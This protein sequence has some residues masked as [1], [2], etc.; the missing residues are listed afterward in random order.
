MLSTITRRTSSRERR[1]IF[2]ATAGYVRGTWHAYTCAREDR[3]REGKQ[4][5]G[6]LGERE[7]LPDTIC[8]RDSCRTDKRA[9]NWPVNIIREKKSVT[10]IKIS[11]GNKNLYNDRKK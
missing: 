4:R 9:R 6:I 7:H 11:Y 8:M 1:A 3:E 10:V 2:Q 5:V